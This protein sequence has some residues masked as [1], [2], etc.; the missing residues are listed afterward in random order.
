[1]QQISIAYSPS[2]ATRKK[3]R[4]SY[5]IADNLRKTCIIRENYV[6]RE[7]TLGISFYNKKVHEQMNDHGLIA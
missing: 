5:E 4:I 6:R 2:I 1:M 3:Q 7:E